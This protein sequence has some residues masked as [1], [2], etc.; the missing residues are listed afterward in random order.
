MEKTQNC[1]RTHV[2]AFVKVFFFKTEFMY[3]FS[4][5]SLDVCTL[6]DVLMSHYSC[7]ELSCRFFTQKTFDASMKRCHL[8]IF[9]PASHQSAQCSV[10]VSMSQSV[11]IVLTLR[12]LPVDIS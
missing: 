1:S 5:T 11:G 3:E 6:R 12:R 10:P 2:V 9:K 8:L 7:H 4:L